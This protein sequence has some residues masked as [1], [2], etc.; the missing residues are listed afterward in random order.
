METKMKYIPLSLF[1]AY[2]G[3]LLAFGTGYQDAPVLLVLGALAAIFQWKSDQRIEQ[4]QA[5]IKAMEDNLVKNNKE[6]GEL[7]S[8]ISGSKIAQAY[9]K[10]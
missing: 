5:S 1:L 4:L 7:R 10:R 2:T 9:S 3:K 8:Y 6:M